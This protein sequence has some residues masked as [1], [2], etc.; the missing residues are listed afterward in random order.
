MLGYEERA[1]RP[2]G[3]LYY[4]ELLVPTMGAVKSEYPENTGDLPVLSQDSHL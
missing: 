4:W 3:H 1:T 2:P